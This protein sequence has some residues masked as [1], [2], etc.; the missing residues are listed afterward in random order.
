[1]CQTRNWL[2]FQRFCFIFAF[3]NGKRF[4]HESS[5]APLEFCL[6]LCCNFEGLWQSRGDRCGIPVAE[7]GSG[8]MPSPDPADSAQQAIG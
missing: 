6:A 2:G 3:G 5:P 7:D 4:P 1:L 8:A